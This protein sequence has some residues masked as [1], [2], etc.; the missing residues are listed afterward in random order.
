MRFVDKSPPQRCDMVASCN[1]QRQRFVS[2]MK[3]KNQLQ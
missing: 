1:K 2:M 3:S